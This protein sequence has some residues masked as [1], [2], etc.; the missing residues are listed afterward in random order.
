[1]RRSGKPENN[2]GTIMILKSLHL[3]AIVLSG[4][5][6]VP[7][8]AHLFALPNKLG[9]DADAYFI[10]QGT[11]RGWALLGIIL[12][13]ALIADG[14]LAVALRGRGSAFVLALV[15]TV[16]L[17]ATL[18]IFFGWTYPAN[19]ATANWTV[20]TADWRELRTQWEYSHAVNALVTLCAF[21]CVSAAAVVDSRSATP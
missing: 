11:Y 16:A 10:A 17:A 14:A 15:A 9:L 21:C 20:V 12:V 2:N 18:A 3:L 13:G 6:L 7:A 1:M 4:L 8:G 19:V 5:A